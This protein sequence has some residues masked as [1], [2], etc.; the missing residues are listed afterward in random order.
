MTVPPALPWMI[1]QDNED[2]LY[3]FIQ[4]FLLR[5]YGSL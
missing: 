3:C 4:L 1:A 5:D 2:V